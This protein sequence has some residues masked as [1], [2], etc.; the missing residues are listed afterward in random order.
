MAQSLSSCVLILFLS[1]PKWTEFTA[2]LYK[3]QPP[4]VSHLLCDS[5][6]CNLQSQVG[7]SSVRVFHH[8]Q[9]ACASRFKRCPNLWM[10]QFI[11]PFFLLLPKKRTTLLYSCLPAWSVTL[12][13]YFFVCVLDKQWEH[14]THFPL[15]KY[16]LLQNSNSGP[17][18]L[19]ELMM[20]MT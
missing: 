11:S 15:L 19:Q 20:K 14:Q 12:C 8:Q 17:P 3:L 18:S 5:R 2:G 4:Y 6:D 13:C 1:L 9:S 10:V 16:T 7:A